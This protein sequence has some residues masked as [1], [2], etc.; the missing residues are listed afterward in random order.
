MREM[1]LR[2]RQPHGLQRKSAGE[3]MYAEMGPREPQDVS[4][5][6]MMTMPVILCVY[7]ES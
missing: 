6:A 4:K 2:C 3:R 1:N 7:R 5:L